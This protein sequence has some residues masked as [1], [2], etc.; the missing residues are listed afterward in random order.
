MLQRTLPVLI[1]LYSTTVAAQEAELEEASEIVKE[2]VEASAADD[3]ESSTAQYSIALSGGKPDPNF[4]ARGIWT[5]LMPAYAIE[6]GRS[7]LDDD[8]DK[9]ALSLRVSQE[10]F[11]PA[12]VNYAVA[13]G[14][15]V[16]GNATIW[17]ITLASSATEFRQPLRLASIGL[18]PYSKTYVGAYQ[19]DWEGGEEGCETYTELGSQN[20]AWKFGSESQIGLL[21]GP[22]PDR[23]SHRLSPQLRVSMALV[24]IES[25]L[26][27]GHML[28]SALILYLPPAIAMAVLEEKLE[29]RPLLVDALNLIYQAGIASLQHYTLHD[30]K[31]WPWDDPRTLAYERPEVALQFTW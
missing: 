24:D 20:G 9:S 25:D 6:L 7:K 31:N 29:H 3:D 28:G 5:G 21:I 22:H 17:G 19:F 23:W 8:G 11:E 18:S 12:E 14:P 27:F 26:R 10:A 1:A 30:H 13:G 16:E 2:T 4:G 15:S